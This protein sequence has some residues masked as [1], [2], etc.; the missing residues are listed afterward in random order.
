[1]GRGAIGRG[2]VKHSSSLEVQLPPG[3]EYAAVMGEHLLSIGEMAERTGVAPSALRFYEAEGLL[4]STRTSGGQ[5]RYP[6]S[7]LRRVAFLRVAQRVGLSLE[8]IRDALATLPESRTPTK[9]DWAR[10]S[11]SWRPRLDEQIAVLE[12]LRDEL[13]SCIGC[14]CL[15]LRE[16][17]LYNP[18]DR[19]GAD[20]PGPRY[21]VVGGRPRLT[22]SPL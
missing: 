4:T 8:E 10:L 1:M 7:E 9:A 22:E 13:S 11:A 21:L 3:G 6:R 17:S 2:L 16:C 14:G 20:G 5:R 12:R 18:L 15:S 19:V